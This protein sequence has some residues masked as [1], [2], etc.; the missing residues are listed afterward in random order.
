[1]EDDEGDR[2]HLQSVVLSQTCWEYKTLVSA[3]NNSRSNQLHHQDQLAGNAARFP[4]GCHA[5]NYRRSE[6]PPPEERA[7]IAASR[8]L[9][10]DERPQQKRAKTTAAAAPAKNSFPTTNL[11]TLR[12]ADT[13]GKDSRVWDILVL[14]LQTSGL[15]Q[16]TS[17]AGF[18]VDLCTLLVADPSSSFFR[19][20]LWRRAATV[21]ARLIRAGDLVRLNR[22]AIRP[23]GWLLR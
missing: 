23:T 20:T 16:I 12:L 4:K 10:K 15:Q 3:D 11:Q 2:P 9:Q 5:D 17:K 19:V 21:G 6:V 8:E 7:G 18:Y 13:S 1:M 22:W 14:V